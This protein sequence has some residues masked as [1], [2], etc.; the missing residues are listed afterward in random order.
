MN[1]DSLLKFFLLCGSAIFSSLLSDHLVPPSISPFTMGEVSEGDR[2]QVM[3]SIRRGDPPF[4]IGW[5]KDGQALADK[6]SRRT[7]RQT[8]QENKS[9]NIP[10]NKLQK[11]T[12]VS[13]SALSDVGKLPSANIIIRSVE[14]ERT[15]RRKNEFRQKTDDGILVSNNR[16]YK[17]LQTS[18]LRDVF[19]IKERMIVPLIFSNP[20]QN[21][22]KFHS[23]KRAARY[24]SS[25]P[26]L[27]D[28]DLK[29]RH[30]DQF[31]VLLVV[32]NAK[33]RHSGNYTCRGSNMVRAA[34]YSAELI[35]KGTL[36]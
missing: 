30:I 1:I 32:S 24:I 9:F 6:H 7:K 14:N 8:L 21:K 25:S 20:V 11:E 5:Y 26:E 23:R 27:S 12:H 16:H 31:S 35:V 3:C 34:S 28:E 13:F 15:A 33:S 4:T 17:S 2:I 22:Y 10:R 29:I 18:L 19:Y 36:R